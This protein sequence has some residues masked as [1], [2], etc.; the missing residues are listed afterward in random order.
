MLANPTYTNTYEPEQCGIFVLWHVV[1][2]FS[3]QC[4]K[5]LRSAVVSN[6]NQRDSSV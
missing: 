6:V 4:H 3:K 5:R 1:Y 2:T